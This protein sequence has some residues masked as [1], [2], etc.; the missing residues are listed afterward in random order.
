MKRSGLFSLNIEKQITFKVVFI[1]KIYLLKY[2]LLI[3][4][5]NISDLIG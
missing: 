3:I 4:M 1:L 2:L 5:K